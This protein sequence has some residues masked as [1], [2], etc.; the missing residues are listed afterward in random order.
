MYSCH[1]FLISSAS[2]R[3]L[4]F[5][6]CIVPIFA[7][8]VPSVSPI[9]LKRSLGF[10]NGLRSRTHDQGLVCVRQESTQFPWKLRGRSGDK[11]NNNLIL[12]THEFQRPHFQHHHTHSSVLGWRIP[13]TGEPGGLPS[14]GLHRVGRDWSDLAAAAEFFSPHYLHFFKRLRGRG[15]LVFKSCGWN[16]EKT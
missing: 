12:L 5:L 2:V 4:P 13:G 10:P 3:S 14:M 11:L 7:W 1:L 15:S 9:F 8:N 6:S 16:F